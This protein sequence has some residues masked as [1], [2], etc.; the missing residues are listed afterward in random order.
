VVSGAQVVALAFVQDRHCMAATLRPPSSPAEPAATKHR[1]SDR[2][3]WWRSFVLFTA[4]GAIWALSVPML[5]GPDE[6]QHAGKAAAVVRGNLT[7]VA[8]YEV[9]GTDPGNPTRVETWVVMP[10]AYPEL[11]YGCIALPPLRPANCLK[12]I[13]RDTPEE[14][15]YINSA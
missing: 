8:R 12:P 7:W 5:V 6:A 14:L 2:A 4:M 1:L 11:N 10:R 13:P 3:V 15:A 9:I